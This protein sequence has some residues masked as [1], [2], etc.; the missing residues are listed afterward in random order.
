MNCCFI[1]GC[2]SIKDAVDKLF[3]FRNLE[4]IVLKNGKKGCQVYTREEQLSFGI[5]DIE[6][7]DPTGAGDSF[8]AGFLCALLSGNSL[9]DAARQATAAASL[10]TGA[11]GPMEGGHKSRYS[12]R[13]D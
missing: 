4:V 3:Q 10:N 1:S 2:D 13:H 12:C 5:Y 7:L 8:D 6:A 11:F 9:L